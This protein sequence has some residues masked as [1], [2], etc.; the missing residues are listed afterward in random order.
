MPKKKKAKKVKKTKKTKKTKLSNKLKT[1][2]KTVDKKNTI[3][4]PDEKPTN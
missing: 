3:S 1:A 2:L 4:G